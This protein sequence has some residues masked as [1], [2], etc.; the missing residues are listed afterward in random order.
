MNIRII[1]SVDDNDIKKVYELTK[2]HVYTYETR[3]ELNIEKVLERIKVDLLNRKETVNKIYLGDK[4]VGYVSI[5]PREDGIELSD[6]YIF[7]EYQNQGIG[8]K[9]LTILIKKYPQLHLYVFKNNVQAVKLYQKLNF[10]I[11]ETHQV[12]YKMGYDYPSTK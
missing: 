11:I 7:K 10:I 8:S 4:H 2:E 1:N 9:V 6:F 12:I 5:I 3:K